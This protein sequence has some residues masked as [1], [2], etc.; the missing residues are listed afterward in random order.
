MNIFFCMSSLRQENYLEYLFIVTV[1]MIEKMSNENLHAQLVSLT[2]KWEIN[3]TTLYMIFINFMKT[4]LFEK[5]VYLHKLNIFWAEKQALDRTIFSDLEWWSN[6]ASKPWPP[7]LK[8]GT[9]TTELLY[10]NQ[11]TCTSSLH[12]KNTVIHHRRRQ[13]VVRISVSHSAIAS[14]ATFWMCVFC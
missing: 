10:C 3:N 14:F 11:N 5:N 12:K 4:A 2:S 6:L 13:N 7:M 9:Q 1:N 8:V